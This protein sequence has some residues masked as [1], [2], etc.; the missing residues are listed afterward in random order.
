[1]EI[2]SLVDIFI[3]II[4]V[5]IICVFVA[6][7]YVSLEETHSCKQF[8]LYGLAVIVGIVAFIYNVGRVLIVWLF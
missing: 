2:L 5:V 1:M 7:M 4:T 8:I 6:D 3:N